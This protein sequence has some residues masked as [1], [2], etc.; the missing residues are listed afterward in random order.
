MRAGTL[1]GALFLILLSGLGRENPVA[2]QTQSGGTEGRL[3]ALE[4][5]LCDEDGIYALAIH[6]GAVFSRDNHRPKA[7]FI[8][9]SLAQAGPLLAAGARAIDIVEAVVMDL[10]DSGIFN[11]G[12]GA[13]AN[14]A[15]VVELD[16][17][18]M[19][20]RELRAGAVASVKASRNPISAARLVMDRSPHVMLVGPDADAFLQ[21]QGSETVEAAY[22]L[23]G[24][25]NF[26][27]VVLP[28]DID[29]VPPGASIAPER[30][31][32]SGSWAG[33]W[34]GVPM[35]HV[36][37]VE[38]VEPED[39]AVIYAF[40][41]NPFT[42]DGKGLFRR[43]PARFVED[44][45]QVIEPKE[46]GGFTTTYRLNADG[47]L[48][49]TTT[50]FE[51]GEAYET[52]LRRKPELSAG[53]SGGTVGAVARDRC[54]DLA[55]G[56]ST[57]GFGTKTPGRV[58]DA[59]IIGAGTY[60]DNATAAISATGHGE[61]FMRHVVAYAITAAMKYGGLSLEQAATGLIEEEL[62]EKGLRGGVVAV[63]RDGNVAMPYNTE[64][65]VRGV[66]SDDVLPKVKVY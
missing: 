65:M 12:R 15:G 9:Q 50:K 1:G 49:V 32:F 25:Q 64:G 59:P 30:A 66:T 19:E 17:S 43:L 33:V 18:I 48:S 20:G 35:N 58:G 37:V 57:G 47:S 24:G 39:V 7:A 42:P 44:A 29:I 62:A 38:R 14:R 34:H 31:A 26:G 60:A 27:D 22:F 4:T 53:H 52:R 28:D 54:G 11:A 40:G 21:A 51:T 13:I 3:A 63:D 61:F 2:A 41:D 36:L 10:E 23:D 8:E 45:L 16:A 56:T 55:A 6:G 46:L 5:G